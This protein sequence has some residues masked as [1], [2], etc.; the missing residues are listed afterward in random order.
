MALQDL[1]NQIPTGSNA[2]LNFDERLSLIEEILTSNE[3]VILPPGV[4][5][6]IIYHNGTTWVALEPGVALQ[7]LQTNGAA[8]NPAWA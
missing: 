4:Q 1:L 8:A 5:G 7:D 3:L 2:G 6:Q